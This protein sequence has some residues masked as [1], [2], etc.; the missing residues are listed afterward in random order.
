MP[1][2]FSCRHFVILFRERPFAV[3]TKRPLVSAGDVRL[4]CGWISSVVGCPV[5]WQTAILLTGVAKPRT[6]NIRQVLIAFSQSALLSDR[7]EWRET[8]A[9]RQS[10]SV[11]F[12]LPQCVALGALNGIICRLSATISNGRG[13]YWII[14]VRHFEVVKGQMSRSRWWRRGSRSNSRSSRARR[15]SGGTSRWDHCRLCPIRCALVVRL[16]TAAPC[17]CGAHP[18]G[19]I[20]IRC[21]PILMARPLC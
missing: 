20:F 9:H 10:R 21:F 2:C 8:F 1:C 5:S 19:S 17:G 4:M 18:I 14:Q 16:G 15:L 6:S 11:A 12:A 3:S 7:W 13:C